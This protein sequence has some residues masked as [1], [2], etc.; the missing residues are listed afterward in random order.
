MHHSLPSEVNRTAPLASV[1]PGTGAPRR[2]AALARLGLL[3]CLGV[4]ILQKLPWPW[5]RHAGFLSV[6]GLVICGNILWWSWAVRLLAELRRR[7]GGWSRSLR[8]GWLLYVLLMLVPVFLLMFRRRWWDQWPTW[9]VMWIMSWNLLV[10]ALG[11]GAAVLWVIALPARGWR[12]RGSSG[13]AVARGAD[14]GPPPADRSLR[15]EAPDPPSAAHPGAELSLSRRRILLAATAAPFAGSLAAVA[16]GRV[17]DGAFVVRRIRMR[18]PRLPERLRGLTITHV[19]DMH[20]GRLFRPEHLPR[21][22]EEAN[23]LR[24]DIVAVTGDI[25]DHS[26]DFLPAACEAIAQLESRHGR[27][28]VMGNHDLIDNPREFVQYV[29]DREPHFLIDRH[30]ALDI[31]GERVQIAGLGWS[32]SDGK[33]RGDPGHQRRAAAA[34]ATADPDAF[35]LALVH[36]PHAFDALAP[37]GVDLTL[38][39]HTHGGQLMLTPPGW[40]VRIGAGSMMFRYLWGEYRRGRSALYVNAGVGNWFPVRVNAPAEIVQIRLV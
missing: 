18:L 3:L 30:L 25:I 1:N 15:S 40:P 9:G 14:L 4:L 16:A 6:V 7:K 31:G 22:I 13:S 33:N 26:N 11:A 32:R 10:A 8:A 12:R 28:V 39:G 34:L 5:P 21:M 29:R 2:W 27:Y 36:H 35:T 37:L 20:T 23:A 17:Q 24:S 38:A 19:S